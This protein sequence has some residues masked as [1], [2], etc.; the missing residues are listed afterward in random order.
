VLADA[1]EA[2]DLP[3]D[4]GATA[5]QRTE[6]RARIDAGQTVPTTFGNPLYP[7]GAGLQG[8]S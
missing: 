3:Y 7:Y 5:A 2:W 6:I 8:W 4:L 1:N